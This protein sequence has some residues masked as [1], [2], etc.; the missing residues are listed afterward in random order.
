MFKLNKDEIRNYEGSRAL[1][2]S[3]TPGKVE[4]KF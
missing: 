3:T 2:F 4:R 1:W